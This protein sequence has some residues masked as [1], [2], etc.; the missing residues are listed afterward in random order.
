M[1][2]NISLHIAQLSL[3][4][5]VLHKNDAA[6]ENKFAIVLAS[7]KLPL[8]ASSK[9][10]LLANSKLPAANSKPVLASSNQPL[11]NSTTKFATQCGT[12]KCRCI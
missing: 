8:L 2:L 11:L 4:L 12:Q 10:P 3:L 1:N 6:S 7:S 9:L 5:S